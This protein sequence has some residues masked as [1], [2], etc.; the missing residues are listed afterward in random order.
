MRGIFSKHSDQC[1][2]R[3]IPVSAD[4]LGCLKKIEKDLIQTLWRAKDEINYYKTKA[5][6]L[7][8]DLKLIGWVFASMTFTD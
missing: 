2:L 3:G 5:E 1:Q 4:L 8:K 6:D 7:V